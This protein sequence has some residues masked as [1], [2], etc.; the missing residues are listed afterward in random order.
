MSN[1]DF[2]KQLDD[3]L[4]VIHNAFIGNYKEEI[5]GLLGL[6]REQIDKITPDTTDLEIYDKLI[7]V[8]RRASAN[9]ISQAELKNRITELGKVA[10][11]IAKGVSKLADLFI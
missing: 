5:E 9:N 3:D 4:D 10:V 7:V 8:V 6:S 2:A 11:T 1:E